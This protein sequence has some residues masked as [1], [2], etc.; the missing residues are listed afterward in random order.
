MHTCCVFAPLK[1]CCLCWGFSSCGLSLLS[2]VVAFVFGS[3][4]VSRSVLFIWELVFCLRVTFS[5]CIWFASCGVFY[6]CWDLAVRVVYVVSRWC[7]RSFVANVICSLALVKYMASS[8][9]INA[10]V[11]CGRTYLVRRLD[12]A[13]LCVFFCCEWPSK[14]LLALAW[15][16]CLRASVGRVTC[17]PL[18]VVCPALCAQLCVTC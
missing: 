16:D 7:F 5:A 6:W 18:P 9:R 10:F 17:Y 4:V 14:V 15:F 2:L 12:N 8:L 1:L 3:I 11:W 13:W